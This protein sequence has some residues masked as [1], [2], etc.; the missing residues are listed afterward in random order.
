MKITLCGS[1]RFQHEFEAWNEALT[2]AGHIVYS[3]AVLPSFHNGEKSWYTD[4]Q[5]QTLDLAHLAK[6]EE[7][8]AIVVLDV[9]GYIGESTK[10]EIEWA[11][12]RGKTIW[13]ISAGLDFLCK[14]PT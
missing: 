5:K 14:V 6:I 13:R 10:R 2:L 12:M 11:E 4:A 1:A 3:L 7:S 8:N 9:N